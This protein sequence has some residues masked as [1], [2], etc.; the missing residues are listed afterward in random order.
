MATAAATTGMFKF[1]ADPAPT[2]PELGV[3]KQIDRLARAERFERFE[4]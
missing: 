1:R 2:I 4:R 3:S